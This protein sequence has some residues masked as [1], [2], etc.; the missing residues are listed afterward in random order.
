MDDVARAVEQVALAYASG[1]G[2]GKFEYSEDEGSV[3][4]KVKSAGEIEPYVVRVYARL[5]NHFGSW[6]S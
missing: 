3:L 4:W 2:G 6:K 5:M 1:G